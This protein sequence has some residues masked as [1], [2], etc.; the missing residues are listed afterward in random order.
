MSATMARQGG[1]VQLEQCDMHLALNEAKIAKE[2]FSRAAIENTQFLIKKPCAEV[3]EEKKRG[4]EFPGHT[5][6]KAPRETHPAKFRQHQTAGC[7][8][9]HNGTA[10]NPH[11]RWRC[12]GTGA[13]PPDRRRQ[14]TAEATPPLPDKPPAPTGNSCGAQWAQIVNSL[15]GYAYSHSSHASAECSTL[16]VS[17]QDSQ[18]NTE[19]DPD[20]LTDEGTSTG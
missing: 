1:L 10:K 18:H 3:H 6:L 4:V 15:A 2:G 8:R 19:F 16:D 7:L 9:C 13:P 14:P 17:A 20:M 5:K 12:Q 11:T